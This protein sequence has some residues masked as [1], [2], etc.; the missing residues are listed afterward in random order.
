MS[1]PRG[2]NPDGYPIEFAVDR[3]GHAYVTEQVTKSPLIT[4][5]GIGTGAAYA[6]ADAFG[7]KFSITGIPVEGTITNIFFIDKDDEGITKD[8]VLFDADFTGT[9]DTAEFTV[10]DDDFAKLV[11]VI[12]IAT[13]RNFKLNQIGQA[14]PALFYKTNDKTPGRLW[15]QWVTRGT[16]NIAAGALPQFF[17]QVVK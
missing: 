16:D 10:S 4:I 6:A 14:T 3:Q 13:F 1:D 17:F 9:A 12:H 15:A 8:L 11:G 2:Q 5:P 7:T